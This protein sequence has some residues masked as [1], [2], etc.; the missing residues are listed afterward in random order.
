[1]E[2]GTVAGGCCCSEQ[3]LRPSGSAL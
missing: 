1:M 2:I 3:V